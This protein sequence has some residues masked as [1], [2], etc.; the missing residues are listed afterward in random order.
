MEEQKKKRV[1]PTVAQVRKLEAEIS[2]LKK[3]AQQNESL[4]DGFLHNQKDLVEKLISYSS[5][6]SK[7]KV[8]EEE[9]EKLR[10]ENAKLIEHCSDSDAKLVRLMRRGFWE[11]VFNKY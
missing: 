8:M 11:R 3:Q 9:L 10:S 2:E 6:V 5:I 1:R 4:I 7:Y